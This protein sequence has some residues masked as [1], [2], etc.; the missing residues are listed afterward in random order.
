MD[1]RMRRCKIIVSVVLAL[2]AVALVAVLYWPLSQPFELKVERI[3]PAE[4][5]TLTEIQ[6]WSLSAFIIAPAQMLVLRILT[7]C[8]S[9]SQGVG[10]NWRDRFDSAE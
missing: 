6:Y 4:C 7:D 9:K 8:R 5:G 1:M 2:I 10:L 3:E